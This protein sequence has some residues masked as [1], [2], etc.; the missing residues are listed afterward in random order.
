M[1]HAYE[2]DAPSRETKHNNV[3]AGRLHTTHGQTRAE[4]WRHAPVQARPAATAR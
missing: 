3:C 2:Y 1:A 4:L